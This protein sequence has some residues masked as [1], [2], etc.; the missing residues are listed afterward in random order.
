MSAAHKRTLP[1]GLDKPAVSEVYQR[2][3]PIYDHWGTLTETKARARGLEWAD[4]RD[5]EAVLEVAVGT[6]LTFA[7]IL[8]CTRGLTVAAHSCGP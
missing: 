1:A 8:S 3:A 5:G 7:D 6:G 4:I 2:V